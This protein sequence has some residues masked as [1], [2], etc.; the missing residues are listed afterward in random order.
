MRHPDVSLL[1]ELGIL[2]DVRAILENIGMAKFLTMDFTTYYTSTL[3]FHAS[4]TIS[5]GNK[6]PVTP[7]NLGCVKFWINGNDHIVSFY[8][9]YIIYGFKQAKK[10]HIKNHDEDSQLWSYVGEGAT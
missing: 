4:L 7:E 1:E 9:L 5:Y 6:S 10:C 8:S 2:G 3:Q